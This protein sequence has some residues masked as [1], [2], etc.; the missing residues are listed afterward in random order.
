MDCKKSG[1]YIMKKDDLVEDIL[2]EIKDIKWK[3]KIMMRNYLIIYA[4]VTTIM[5]LILQYFK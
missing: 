5:V 4:V 2:T 1:E 3:T